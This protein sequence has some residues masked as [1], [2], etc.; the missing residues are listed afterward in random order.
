LGRSRDDLVSRDGKPIMLCERQQGQPS[1]WLW[2]GVE[3]ADT[4]FDEFI[5]KNARIRS[6][7][8]NF[9]WAYEFEV[10]NPD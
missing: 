8:Q 3:D 6:P 4:L 10:E 2:I 7:P 5:S 9:T 1:T